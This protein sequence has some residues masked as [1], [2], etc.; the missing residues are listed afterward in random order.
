[1]GNYDDLLTRPRWEPSPR[2]PRMRTDQRAKI[3][4]PFAS[5]RGFGNEISRREILWDPR[6]VLSEEEQAGLDSALRGL[7]T[8]I[9]GGERPAVRVTCFEEHEDGLGLLRETGGRV[10]RIDPALG[11]L[12]LDTG[13]IPLADVIAVE[14]LPGENG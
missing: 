8:A 6:P 13:T 14:R 10:R 4:M 7:E 12:I 9:R 5:L 3:F 1:M 11:R 2:H